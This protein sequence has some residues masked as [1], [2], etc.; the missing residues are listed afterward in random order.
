M[1]KNNIFIFN[2]NKK[3]LKNY[4]YNSYIY[5]RYYRL[6]FHSLIFKGN[7][8][9]AFKFLIELRYL[10]KKQELVDPFWVI[11]IAF[12]KITPDIILFPKKLGG[13]IQGVPL[14]IGERKQYTFAV[15]WVVKLL[16]DKFRIITLKQVVEILISAIY[17]KGLAIEK[18]N[19]DIST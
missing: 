4:N 12:M 15:K 11:L 13:V 7:K 19:V 5:Y 8:L 18:K 1:I 9:W 14:S 17:D 16:K 3:Y 10:I 2:K 6:F